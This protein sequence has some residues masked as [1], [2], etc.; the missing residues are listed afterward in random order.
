MCYLS[1]KRIKLSKLFMKILKETHPFIKFVK[2]S[3]N[4]GPVDVTRSRTKGKT[5]SKQLVLALR[6]R[7]SA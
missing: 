1:A 6:K 7:N 2:I 4:L 3:S 5:P